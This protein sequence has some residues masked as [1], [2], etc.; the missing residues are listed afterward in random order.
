MNS[1]LHFFFSHFF[2]LFPSFPHTFDLSG[3]IKKKNVGEIDNS[4][5]DSRPGARARYLRRKRGK[6]KIREWAYMFLL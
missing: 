4:R 5:A 3:K 6:K 1:S 2:F